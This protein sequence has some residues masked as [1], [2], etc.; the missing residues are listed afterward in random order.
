MENEHCPL[1]GEDRI[2]L[3]LLSNNGRGD[4]VKLPI[5]RV[6]GRGLPGEAWS[7]WSD[8]GQPV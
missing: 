6:T 8:L 4:K 3:R 5:N 1:L 2:L 7:D